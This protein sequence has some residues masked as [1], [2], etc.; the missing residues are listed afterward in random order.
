MIDRHKANPVTFR[1]PPGDRAW[2]YRHSEE[3]GRAVGAILTEALSEYR[4]KTETGTKLAQ[5]RLEQS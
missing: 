1:P 5:E 3:T 4:T 2:L